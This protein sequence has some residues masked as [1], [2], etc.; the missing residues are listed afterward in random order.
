[1]W[2]R[3]SSDCATDMGGLPHRAA[4]IIANLPASTRSKSH[5]RSR[6]PPVLTAITASPTPFAPAGSHN[7]R[8]DSFAPLPPIAT[9]PEMQQRA[10]LLSANTTSA[11]PDADPHAPSSIPP[12]VHANQAS[13]EEI[14]TLLT[15][16][17]LARPNTRHYK[18][19]GPQHYKPGRKLDHLRS[20]EPPFLSTPISDSQQR[21]KPFVASGPNPYEPQGR[22]VDAKW[23][24]E[25]MPDLHPDWE[26]HVEDEVQPAMGGMKGL[27][28][29]GKWLISPERQERTVRLFWVSDGF[30]CVLG[31]GLVVRWMT[32]RSSHLWTLFGRTRMRYMSRYQLRMH[33]LVHWCSGSSRPAANR[34]I[35]RSIRAWALCCC[36]Q[37]T[38]H[39]AVLFFEEIYFR[40]LGLR[41]LHFCHRTYDVGLRTIADII[42]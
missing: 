40:S 39:S 10:S 17:S 18:P 31:L 24:E 26:G 7:R 32:L 30:L 11:N 15:P 12:W 41:T 21:W 2:D 36:M 16:P 23:M 38:E 9:M 29:K 13:G 19:P 1:M 25:N 22:I 8:R 14:E 20:A 6:P 37:D 28:Y 34:K 33:Y 5:T 27:M 42:M 4:S 3:I 35:A